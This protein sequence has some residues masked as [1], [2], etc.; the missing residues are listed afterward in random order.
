MSYIQNLLDDV[1]WNFSIP[2]GN[3]G[4]SKKVE[5]EFFEEF[6]EEY[7]DSWEKVVLPYPPLT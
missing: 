6:N 2:L 1:A 5:R 7:R 4:F 3:V